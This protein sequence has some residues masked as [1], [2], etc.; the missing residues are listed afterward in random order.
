V[1]LLYIMAALDD[2]VV[3][4]MVKNVLTAAQSA[5]TPAELNELDSFVSHGPAAEDCCKLLVAYPTKFY[6]QFGVNENGL[7]MRVYAYA[8]DV[9]VSLRECPPA[10]SEQGVPPTPEENDQ[11]AETAAT[12]AFKIVKAINCARKDGTLMPNG[13]CDYTIPPFA[14]IMEELGQCAGWD[15]KL[16]V[17]LSS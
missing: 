13:T 3:Y 9:V 11:Y 10:V 17:E 14:E 4:D 7:D 12:H 2:T 8:V 1:V 6:P 5:F 15:I 16:S